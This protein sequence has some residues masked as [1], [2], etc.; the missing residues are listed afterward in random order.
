MTT[1]AQ[2]QIPESECESPAPDDLAERHDSVNQV[3]GLLETLP[4]NQ[5][6][7]VRL[8]F[9]NELSYREISGI[10]GLSVTNVGFLI[11]RALKTLR[12][13]LKHHSHPTRTCS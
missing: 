11:H 8:K 6:E 2:V 10:T 12:L 4:D 5:Q 7:V 9:Q 13:R 3:L 1:L